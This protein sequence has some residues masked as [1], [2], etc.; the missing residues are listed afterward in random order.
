M[1]LA[2]IFLT[3]LKVGALTF[4]G[5]YGILPILSREVVQ[6]LGW[7][8][9]EEV[10]DCFAVAQCLPGVIAVN[11]SVQVGYR[12]KG[13]A[14]GIAAA[15]GVVSPS[16][17]IIMALSAL[18]S[19]FSD[20]PAVSSAFAGIRVCVFVL[21]MNTLI[22]LW[23]SAVADKLSIIIFAAVFAVAVFTN[24]SVAFLVIGAGIVGV[25]ASTLRKG[26]GK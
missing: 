14:G 12:K 26:A 16:L 2:Q 21:I 23:K 7:A 11:T 18:I 20:I 1:L 9:E 4:G 15:L 22:K 5:G 17:V 8:T 6:K 19:S 24:L 10:A 13:A 3:F 25:A